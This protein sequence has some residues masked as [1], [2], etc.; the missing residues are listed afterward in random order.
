MIINFVIFTNGH[1]SDYEGQFLPG[2]DTVQC[3]RQLASYWRNV[4]SPSTE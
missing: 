2:S 4:Q 1:F 3:A